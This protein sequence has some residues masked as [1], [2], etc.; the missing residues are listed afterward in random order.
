MLKNLRRSLRNIF[1]ISIFSLSGINAQ[2]I[3]IP[4]ENESSYQGAWN[5]SV[6][7]PNYLAAYLR[8]L[9]GIHVLSSSA[10]TKLAQDRGFNVKVIPDFEAIQFIASEY[11]FRYALFGRIDKFNISRF[12]AGEPTLAGYEAYACHIEGTVQ[13]FDID[14]NEFIYTKSIN[15]EVND[16]G[17]GLT[18]LGKPT[19]EKEQFYGLDAMRFGGEEFNKTLVGLTMLNFAENL[20]ADITRFDRNIL[21]EDLDIKV[22][23][24]PAD[25]ALDDFHLN[26]EIKKGII[27]IYD[28]STGEAF[29]NLG[30]F[31]EMKPGEE[32]GIYAEGDSLFDPV[33][34]EF[35]GVSDKKISEMEII[36]VRGERLSLAVVKRNR[37]IVEKGME[38]R[39]LTIKLRD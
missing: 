27:L 17:I 37:E 35:L 18:L 3:F 14:K 29:I 22:K 11:N 24:I 39:K 12:L 25:N 5:L 34:N 4:F 8:E 16:R 9:H 15:E 2:I 33:S 23:R 10:A 38:V 21:K 13:L 19:E 30:S 32:I 26:T 28:I 20:S 1:F 31:D 6:E 36:E 7:V